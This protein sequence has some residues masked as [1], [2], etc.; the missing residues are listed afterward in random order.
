M[1]FAMSGCAL[2]DRLDGKGGSG[3]EME[4]AAVKNVPAVIDGIV[5]DSNTAVVADTVTDVFAEPDI[6][7]ERVSQAL[8]NQPVSI[9]LEQSG[10]VKA[11]V[12]DGSEGWIRSKFVD[13]DISSIYGKSCTGRIIVTSREKAVYTSPKGGVTIKDA[14][15]GSAFY[16]FNN[17]DGAYEVFLPG[18]TTG[19]LRGSGIIYL[20]LEES[21]PETTKEDFASTALKFKG[22]VYLLNGL[23]GRGIDSSGLLYVCGKIN[24]IA[25]PRMVEEQMK[26]G[27]EVT[28]PKAS[29][30]SGS[31][32]ESN[33]SVLATGD[34]LFFSTDTDSGRFP[35]AGIY[36][37]D[38]KYI[39]SSKAS[40][41]VKV[42]TIGNKSAEGL[43]VSAR[44]LFQ[45]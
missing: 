18:N 24:G 37:G 33:A 5:I 39:Y 34:L 31:A 45:D 25:I 22:T 7:S 11:R 43:L 2:K 3:E 42:D 26:C 9:L 13:R 8:Y 40:G 12:P 38:G 36:L 41:Y 16:A 20:G 4:A 28:L 32:A 1:L 23:S 27:E 29:D 6:R 35:Y 14:M 10:W 44:R 19:W 30:A 21:I 17:A 15:L